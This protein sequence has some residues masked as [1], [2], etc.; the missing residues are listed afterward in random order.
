MKPRVLLPILVAALFLAVASAASAQIANPVQLYGHPMS[1][2]DPDVANWGNNYFAACTSDYGQDNPEPR[3]QKM[4]SQPDAFPLYFSSDLQHW[5]FMNYV[6]TPQ[7]SSSASFPCI[8]PAGNWPGGEFW[9]P[10]IHKIN[11][12]WTAFYGCQLKGSRKWVIAQSWS[13]SLT[14]GNWG[15]KVLFNDPTAAGSIDPSIAPDPQNP[16]YYDL[17]FMSFPAHIYIAEVAV[18]PGIH[19]VSTPKLISQPTL[20]W[21]EGWEEGPVIWPQWPSPY[22]SVDDLFVNAASTW[23]NTYAIAIEQAV[24]PLLDL[25]TK[26]STPLMQGGNGLVSTGIGAQPFVGPGGQ[27]DMTIAFHVQ[28]GSATQNMEGRFLAFAHLGFHQVNGQWWPYVPGGVAP[29]SY[30]SLVSAAKLQQATNGA[31]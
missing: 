10:E 22:T 31:K 25:W 27:A 21:E 14:S 16:G 5:S 26:Q 4:G 30:S 1:C 20:A 3:A 6:I 15:T 8:P 9:A 29:Q 23:N 12:W 24:N 11:G 18:N 7:D 19:L 17:V 13:K 2:P 28:L